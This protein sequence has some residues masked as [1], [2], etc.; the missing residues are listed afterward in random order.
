MEMSMKKIILSVFICFSLSL[1]AFAGNLPPI[2][3][4]NIG[5]KNKIFYN[6][7][8]ESW[9][10]KGDKKTDIYFVKVKGFGDYTD[11]LDADKNFVFSSECEYEFIYNNKLIG[12]SN[13]ESNFYEISYKDGKCIKKIVPFDDVVE[14]LSDFKVIKASEFSELTNSIKVKKHFS[15]LNILIL[16]DTGKD[17]SNYVFTSGNAKFKTY[18]L[19][20]PGILQIKPAAESVNIQSFSCY[21]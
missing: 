5:I 20:G 16:N 2:K 10:K 8:T 7:D 15:D 13:S 17:Y 21:I 3:Y 14:M 19:N 6:A 4:K 9:S 12:Y 1:G 11:Y 18:T